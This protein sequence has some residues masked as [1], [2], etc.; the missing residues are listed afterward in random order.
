MSR[1]YYVSV[2][3]WVV[4]LYPQLKT[5]CEELGICFSSKGLEVPLVHESGE[6]PGVHV[7]LIM[8]SLVMLCF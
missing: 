8:P 4:T 7:S 2:I 1:Y 6:S 5:V 3:F